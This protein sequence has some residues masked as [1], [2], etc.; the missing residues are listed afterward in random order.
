MRYKVR[1][2]YYHKYNN[3]EDKDSIFAGSKFDFKSIDL[4][5]IKTDKD[6]QNNIV[7]LNYLKYL[8]SPNCKINIKS[9]NFKINKIITFPLNINF[10]KTE[11]LLS[12]FASNNLYKFFKKLKIFYLK[13]VILINN[14]YKNKNNKILFLNRK[15]IIN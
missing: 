14:C 9:R 7:L 13:K 12:F 8:D 3:F 2:F 6:K 10:N 5:F 1:S 4:S 15:N 11:Y